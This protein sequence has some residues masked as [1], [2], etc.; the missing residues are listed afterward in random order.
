MYNKGNPPI[1]RV[2]LLENLREGTNLFSVFSLLKT[3][4]ILQ[5]NVI[6][7]GLRT[8]KFKIKPLS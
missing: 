2:V 8:L 7:L 6:K 4:N 5:H 3:K 1:Y